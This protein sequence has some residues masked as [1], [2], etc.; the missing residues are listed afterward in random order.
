MILSGRYVAENCYREL[1][2]CEEFIS[3]GWNPVFC[4]PGRKLH[5]Q[6]YPEEYRNDKIF[7]EYNV[8][9]LDNSREYYKLLRFLRPKFI[10]FGS[11]ASYAKLTIASR[12]LGY[13]T[14]NYN[15]TSG[16]D[17]WWHYVNHVFV[18]GQFVVNQLLERDRHNLLIPRRSKIHV[19]GSVAHERFGN[20]TIKSRSQY[21]K[22]YGLNENKKWA[23]FFPKGANLRVKLDTWFKRWPVNRRDTWIDRMHQLYKE[24]CAI[25]LDSG[26]ELIIKLHPSDYA[27]YIAGKDEAKQ[28]FSGLE[29]VKILDPKDTYST[30]EHMDI[31]LGTI[32]HSALD[33]GYFKKPFIYVD[34]N[35]FEKP[36]YNS[37]KLDKF[38]SIPAGPSSSW[39]DH[40][41]DR[42]YIWFPSWL[43]E[44]ATVEKLA[45]M[46]EKALSGGVKTEHHKMFMNEY[47]GGR[48]IKAS[49]EITRKAISLV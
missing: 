7:K 38:L 48:S 45:I 37:W 22:E 26:L 3:N 14:M 47:W 27:G 4:I 6:G 2:I 44:Y 20:I 29:G 39:D 25:T 5:P 12:T 36:N 17:H 18:K 8:E 43:G 30:Y 23:V 41:P 13:K 49:T 33:I 24:I 1:N 11:Y 46:I 34:T 15:S 32:T 21:A 19:T 40:N 28:F 42:K 35:K 16:L 31:G 9:H 10:L